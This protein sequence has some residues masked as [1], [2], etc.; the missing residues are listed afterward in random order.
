MTN[1]NYTIVDDFLSEED[2]KKMCEVITDTGFDWHLED[3]ITL[4]Q[5]DKDI[6][7]YLCHV[8][9]N[10]SSLYQSK[11]F[12]VIFPLLKKLEP[13]ALM[14]VKAN[15][16]L[17]HGLGIKEHAEHTDYPFEHKGAL[18]SLNTCDGY[19][20]INGEKIPSVANRMIFFNP[21]KPHCSTSCS[22][23]KTRMNININY[24]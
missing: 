18:Y 16:Y 20:K 15:L 14:R 12:E 5:K 22:D 7:F 2:F 17:N 24:F 11:F 23:T 4:E 9:Y 3:K 19:T 6:F 8:F 1:K 21:S 13:K 10:Q